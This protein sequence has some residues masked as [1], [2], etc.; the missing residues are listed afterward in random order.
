MSLEP[1]DFDIHHVRGGSGAVGCG[2]ANN[3]CIML[4][5]FAKLVREAVLARKM[6][7]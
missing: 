2:H 7:S 3:G 1:R 6:L 5:G 4:D